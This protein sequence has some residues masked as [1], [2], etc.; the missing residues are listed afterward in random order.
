MCCLNHDQLHFITP[1]PQFLF[2]WPG[3]SPQDE[4]VSWGAPI[5][6][7]LMPLGSSER[8]VGDER[9]Q[10][11]VKDVVRRAASREG[12]FQTDRSHFIAL[13]EMEE[14]FLDW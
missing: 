12:R 4:S 2:P 10:L 11:A 14:G 1:R 8:N 5:D 9:R 13:E 6:A 3:I 7:I